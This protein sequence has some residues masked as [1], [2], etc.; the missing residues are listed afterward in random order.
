MREAGRL[1]ARWL[2]SWTRRFKCIIWTLA[3]WGFFVAK[4]TTSPPHAPVLESGLVII[5]KMK[6]V[7]GQKLKISREN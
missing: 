7:E 3:C 5:I 4:E 6:S 1:A 2:E